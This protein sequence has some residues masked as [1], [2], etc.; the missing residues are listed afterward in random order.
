MGMVVTDRQQISEL[1][2]K[3][4]KSL[5]TKL[6]AEIPAF[7]GHK[8]SSWKGIFRWSEEDQMWMVCDDEAGG[9][10][11]FWTAFGLNRPSQGQ[12]VSIVAEIN[13]PIKGIDRRVGGVFIRTSEGTFQVAHRGNIGGGRKGISKSLFWRNYKGKRLKANDGGRETEFAVI[14]NL[15][16]VNL[17]SEIRDFVANIGRLKGL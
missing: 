2:S 15:D 1:V 17:V 8:G 14:G 9:G 10:K 13:F 12:N 11:R 7:V 16:S 5:L 4:R 3:F 6:Q